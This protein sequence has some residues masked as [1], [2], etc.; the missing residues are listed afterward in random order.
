MIPAPVAAFGCD[1]S[2]GPCGFGWAK[3]SLAWWSYRAEASAAAATLRSSSDV[4]TA[5]RP[6]GTGL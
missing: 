5:P 2:R 1:G 4:V 6:P 3:P